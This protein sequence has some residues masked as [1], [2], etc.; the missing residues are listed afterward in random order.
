MNDSLQTLRAEARRLAHGRVPEGI[1]YPARFR[2]AAVT[3][4]R[5]QLRRGDAFDRVAQAVGVTT[6]TLARWL[7]RR[8]ALVL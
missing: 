7:R 2:A 6:P 8:P 4:A 3:L 1:R 5:A